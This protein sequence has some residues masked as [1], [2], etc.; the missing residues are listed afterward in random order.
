HPALQPHQ[1]MMSATPIPRTLAMSFYADLD[2]STIDQMPPGR[3]PV[4]TKLLSDARREEVLRRVRDACQQGRQA[5]WVCPLIEESETLQLQTALETCE[6]LRKTFPD[7]KVGLV[8]GR[9]ANHEK[10]EVMAAFQA[11][12]IHLLVATTVVEVGMDVPNASL[13]VIEHA[14]R[15]GL[16]QLHQLR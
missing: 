3:S 1:L 4:L 13:M 5:Y 16:A 15:M 7:L 12:Q 6:E 10:T 11:N 9:L 8:H 2:V 14:E